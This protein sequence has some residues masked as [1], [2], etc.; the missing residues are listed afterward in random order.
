MWPRE[1]VLVLTRSRGASASPHCPVPMWGHGKPRDTL[2]PQSPGR[3][4]QAAEGTPREVCVSCGRHCTRAHT[5]AR[6][7]RQ[8]K[9]E[10]QVAAGQP[11]RP[12]GPA[13]ESRSG[14]RCARSTEGSRAVGAES[15]GPGGGVL[16]TPT[17]WAVW[18]VPPARLPAT[19]LPRLGAPGLHVPVG[20]HAWVPAEHRRGCRRNRGRP[21]GTSALGSR[22]GRGRDRAPAHW[23]SR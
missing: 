21:L 16:P 19:G 8:P 6:V 14:R 4:K 1:R 12:P 2:W 18:A 22:P 10:G 17:Q 15:R 23:V 20:P 11:S 7:W 3:R 13:S 5:V 9:P